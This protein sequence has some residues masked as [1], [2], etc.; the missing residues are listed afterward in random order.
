MT[1]SQK[2]TTLLQDLKSAEEL[3]IQKYAKYASDAC[4]GALKNLF[5]EICQTEQ[6]HY[7]TI[8]NFLGESASGTSTGADVFQQTQTG[9]ILDL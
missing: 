3:C 5:T 4:D 6:K 9:K 2:E 1:L 8:S 7:D